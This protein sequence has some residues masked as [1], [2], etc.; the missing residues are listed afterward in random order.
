MSRLNKMGGSR[1]DYPPFG[2]A[3]QR[4]HWR[5]HS[6]L[7]ECSFHPYSH[8]A[9]IARC[10]GWSV[11]SGND[12]RLFQDVVIGDLLGAAAV[13]PDGLYHAMKRGRDFPFRFCVSPA[14][15][16]KSVD[17]LPLFFGTHATSFLPNG[18]AN[19]KAVVGQQSNLYHIL[20]YCKSQELVDNSRVFGVR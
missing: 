9:H 14:L 4:R 5:E 19:S 6:Q 20:S 12:S 15:G 7:L 8:R 10:A 1:L 13:L 3:H 16:N 2:S 17:L 18:E 11:G